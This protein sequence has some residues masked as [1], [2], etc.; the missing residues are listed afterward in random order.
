M[1]MWLLVGKLFVE[2]YWI[3]VC[4]VYYYGMYN[5]WLQYFYY[6]VLIC[7]YQYCDMNVCDC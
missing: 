7:Y 1:V 6:Y 5:L 2:C 4:N 3:I